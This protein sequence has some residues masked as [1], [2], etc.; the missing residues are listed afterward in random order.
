[1]SERVQE[2]QT[3]NVTG[4]ASGLSTQGE[5]I[6]RDESEILQ[7]IQTRLA[8]DASEA[9]ENIEDLD[10]QLIELRDMIAEA[11]EEDMA[12]LVDQMHQVA[13]LSQ[14]RGKGRDLPIDPN[15]P[16]FGHMRVQ[17]ARSGRARDVLIGKRTMLDNGD[18][19][20]IVD[21]RNAPISRLYYR[22]DEDEEYEEEFDNRQLEGRVLVRRSVAVSDTVLR[23]V[24]APQGVYARGRDD[25]W[26]ESAQAGRPTLEGGLGQAVRPPKGQL[27]V[28]EDDALRQDKRLQEI[29][30]FIDKDQFALITAEDSGIVLIQG[31]AG[32][33]KTTVA[34]HR[35]AYLA[36]QDPDRF[37]PSKMMIV[38]FNEALVEYIKYVLPSLGVEGVTVT[39]YR[40]WTAQLLRRLKVEVPPRRT[41]STP[42]AVSRFKKHPVLIA[43]MEGLIDSQTRGAEEL[44]L[45]RLGQRN[46]AADVMAAWRS[47][48]RLPLAE[49]VRRLGEWLRKGPGS[50]TPGAAKAAADAA[51]AV[52]REEVGDLLNDWMELLG[53]AARIRDAVDR[54]A[55]GA[56]SEGE[57]ATI[58]KWC[59]AKVGQLIASQEQQADHR[60]GARED[61]ADLSDP[62]E[63]VETVEPVALDGEDD[64][65]LLRLCQLKFGG[66]LT[67]R[68]RVEYEHVVVDEAQD[69]CP[70]EVRVLLDCVSPGKSVTIAGDKAQKMIFDNGFVDWPQLL[71]DAGL[72]HVEVQPLRI[73]YRST[74]QVM[75]LARHVLGPLHDAKDDLI[76]RDGAPVAFFDF[77]DV[78]ESVAFLGEAL[79]S[80]MRR[81]PTASVAVICRY[82]TQ[83]E[84]YYDALTV[85]EVPR[86][87][88]VKQQDF[89]F[90]PG[91]DVTDV[92]QVK[93]LEFDYVIVADPT[94]QNYPSTVASRH[95]LHIACTRTAYQLWLVCAGQPSALLPEDLVQTG[96]LVEPGS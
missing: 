91:I 58:T 15:S 33:G 96:E 1:M 25:R 94:A 38:V 81:E 27:G 30:A 7:R 45:E 17:E 92:R 56:F 64:A 2:P 77:A 72:E 88:L 95:L 48:E 71:D 40:R 29:T 37:A 66:L 9:S 36:F 74:R 86:L 87:R 20:A 93:G 82:P 90:L 60:E 24:S 26:R 32:S 8:R 80:L 12:S 69:L 35:V 89:G 59:A 85:A 10:G 65:I 70:L 75:A 5:S 67:A 51:L 22:Y 16:Y 39:T 21:W 50:R 63:V 44:L 6:V 31:G 4:D 19:L 42:E 23:R 76:A 57:L 34:L 11:K 61:G 47:F 83:A 13:A 18:G 84:M 43:M 68:G 79:R 3:G 46:G 73:T 53:D 14:R 78:G 55:P 49:R 41:D 28:G 54:T 52:I 62:D